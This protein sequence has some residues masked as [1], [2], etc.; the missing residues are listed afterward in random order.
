MIP[1]G[2]LHRHSLSISVPISADYTFA[3]CQLLR[4]VVYTPVVLQ[5]L[6]GGALSLPFGSDSGI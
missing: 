6:T 2:H 4:S 1:N 5:Y 3:Q